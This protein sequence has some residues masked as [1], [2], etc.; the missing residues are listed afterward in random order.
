MKYIIQC[1]YCHNIYT[2]EEKNASTPFVCESCG[3][4]GSLGN[5]IQKVIDTREEADKKKAAETAARKKAMLR[6]TSLEKLYDDNFQ[7]LGS[8]N[9]SKYPEIKPLPDKAY[10]SHTIVPLRSTLITLGIVAFCILFWFI[11]SAIS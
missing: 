10:H 9:K 5:V 1:P 3:G 6:K 4:A 8:K 11:L 7:F 2:V